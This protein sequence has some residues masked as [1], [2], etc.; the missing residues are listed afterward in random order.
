[1]TKGAGWHSEGSDDARKA[2]PKRSYAERMGVRGACVERRGGEG[3]ANVA[4]LVTRHD[5]VAQHFPRGRAKYANLWL[6]TA[7]LHRKMRRAD[8]PDRPGASPADT[9]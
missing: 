9:G 5:K 3:G 2:P 1:M 4:V 7:V 8:G 6:E